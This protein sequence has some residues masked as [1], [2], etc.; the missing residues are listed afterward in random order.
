MW[1][2]FLFGVRSMCALFG[3]W[4]RS[5]C[6]ALQSIWGLQTTKHEHLLLLQR[7]FFLFSCLVV[8]AVSLYAFSLLYCLHN[9]VSCRPMTLT[10]CLFCP[11]LV[12][13]PKL[14]PLTNAHIPER[15]HWVKYAN[16]QYLCQPGLTGRQARV[17]MGTVFWNEAKKPLQAPLCPPFGFS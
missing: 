10:F 14:E 6:C 15:S 5:L 12:T 16:T 17:F 4:L 7:G 11:P 13:K 2:R 9:K 1:S 8:T 3:V